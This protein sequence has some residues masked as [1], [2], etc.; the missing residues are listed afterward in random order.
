LAVLTRARRLT[1]AGSVERKY[2]VGSAS[3]FGHSDQ[4]SGRA[5]GKNPLLV[6][7]GLAAGF[8]PDQYS[9]FEVVTG[10]C[11]YG[12]VATP[13]R[14]L[15]LQSARLVRKATLRGEHRRKRQ[16]RTLRGMLLFQDGSTHAWVPGTSDKQDLIVTLDD[17]T[18][19]ITS[20]FLTQ[21]E[22]ILSS[23]TGLAQTIARHGLLGVFY[24]ERGS[25][26]FLS[27]EAGGGVDKENL[28][29]VGR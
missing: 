16:R 13:H 26:Y 17:A 27:P 2:F 21:Q 28:T 7:L 9:R 24:T 22:G 14:R 10:S 5:G 23:F 4:E 19:H 8:N 20:I 11:G 25:R 3:P 12:S 15:A 18:D 29:Q 6:M 1:G